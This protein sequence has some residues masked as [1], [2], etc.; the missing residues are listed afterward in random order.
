M[1]AIVDFIEYL[2]S[3]KKALVYTTFKMDDY[4]RVTDKLKAG[5]IKYRVVSRSNASQAGVGYGAVNH[6]YKIYVKK[7]E[8]AKAQYCIQKKAN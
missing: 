4:Y 1:T 6:I 8:K 3:T 7:S 2:F 5:S